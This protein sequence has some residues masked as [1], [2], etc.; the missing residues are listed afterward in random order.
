MAGRGDHS[1]ALALAASLALHAAGAGWV[2]QYGVFTARP[3]PRASAGPRVAQDEPIFRPESPVVPPLFGHAEGRGAAANASAGEERMTGPDAAQA[4]AFL[5][6]DPAGAGRVGDDPSMSVLPRAASAFAPAASPPP[7]EPADV[8]AEPAFGLPSRVL[9]LPPAPR[10]VASASPAPESSTPAVEAAPAAPA[11]APPA[12]ASESNS[13]PDPAAAVAPADRAS[14]NAGGEDDTSLVRTK[15]SPLRAAAAPSPAGAAG[16]SAPAADPAIMSD[17]E[18]DPFSPGT[19]EFF[20]DGRVDVRFGRKVKT[21]RPRLSLAD[22]YDLVS[23]PS[24]RM[25]V[26]V[27]LDGEGAVRMVDILKST[28]SDSADQAVKVALYQWWFEP[29]KGGEDV[30]EFPIVWH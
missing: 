25:L 7:E 28:G 20:R 21:V 27:R 3:S 23:L 14:I 1:F 11:A 22:R 29:R 18:S 5:S 12:P 16:A 15:D 4:Q 19:A 8:P 6:R 24:P 30:V 13:A 26:R 9:P 17:S 2:L 10:R